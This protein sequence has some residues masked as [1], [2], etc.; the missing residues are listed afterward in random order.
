MLPKLICLMSS[1]ALLWDI[2]CSCVDKS[3]LG[4]ENDSVK[5]AKAVI[6]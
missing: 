4:E 3:V 2:E 5:T 1:P 6:A